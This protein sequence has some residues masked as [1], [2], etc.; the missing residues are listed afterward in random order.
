MLLQGAATMIQQKPATNT[1]TEVKSIHFA[2][3][4]SRLDIILNSSLFFANNFR[5]GESQ[6]LV[7]RV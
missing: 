6:T 7:L 1:A 2:M 4:L 5:S 3:V